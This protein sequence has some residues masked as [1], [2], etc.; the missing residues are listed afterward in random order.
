MADV[1]TASD[2]TAEVEAT[3]ASKVAEA[4]LARGRVAADVPEGAAKVA[5]E[6]AVT[7]KV[8]EVV[9][10]G[11]AKEAEALGV[12][13]TSLVVVAV[14]EAKVAE[15]V[16]VDLSITRVTTAAGR[17]PLNSADPDLP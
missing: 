17:E 6:V 14:G 16:G 13:P 3:G 12:A 2:S 1:V 7:P 11:D 9:A 8:A 5:E 15:A 10:V 4:E